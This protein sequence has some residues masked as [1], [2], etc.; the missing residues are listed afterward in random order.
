MSFF[1]SSKMV[2]RGIHPDGLNFI[3][4]PSETNGEIKIILPVLKNVKYEFK[5]FINNNSAVFNVFFNNAF[6]ATMIIENFKIN[7]NLKN[8]NTGTPNILNPI[9]VITSIFKQAFT[10][11]AGKIITPGTE[12]G[13][14]IE[15]Q[16]IAVWVKKIRPGVLRG[17]D[18]IA[19]QFINIFQ[20]SIETDKKKIIQSK[21]K[22]KLPINPKIYERLSLLQRIGINNLI[23]LG[24]MF[25][26]YSMLK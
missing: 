24:G 12:I 26:A 14:L 8:N 22:Y 19:K 3:V 15:S 16:A 5:G 21:Q 18:Y 23:I 9:D 11:T 1:K 2:V 17:N 13:E 7:E 25:F 6:F 4:S 20:N 10:G